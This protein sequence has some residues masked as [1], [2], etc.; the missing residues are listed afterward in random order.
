MIIA[1][2]DDEKDVRELLKNK[3]RTIC[4]DAELVLYQTGKELLAA[5]DRIFC[6]WIFRC[7]GK[8]G[9]RRRG[10]SGRDLLPPFL[11]L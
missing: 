3:I 6:F 9:W 10:N 11:F 8:T 5:R 1:I 2:C 4:P 7:Q